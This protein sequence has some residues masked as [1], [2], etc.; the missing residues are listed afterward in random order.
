MVAYFI[1]L[2]QI[3]NERIL[4]YQA[5]VFIMVL[6]IVDFFVKTISII[7]LMIAIKKLRAQELQNTSLSQAMK[8]KEGYKGVVK[9]FKHDPDKED[10]M[11]D[12]SSLEKTLGIN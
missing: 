3:R 7:L 5:S 10:S 1:A 2:Q 6:N 4:S 12:S 9:S 11:T 8:T